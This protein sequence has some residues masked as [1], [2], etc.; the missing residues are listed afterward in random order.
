MRHG[1]VDLSRK[2]DEA[3]F[4]P[5][6]PGLPR[7]VNGSIGMQWPPRPGLIERHETERLGLGGVNDFPNVDAKPVAHQ[8]ISFTNPILTARNVF[9]SNF[10]IRRRG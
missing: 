9:S 1:A 10:T 3:W 2:F 7:Q 5:A 8:A 4:E 6:L